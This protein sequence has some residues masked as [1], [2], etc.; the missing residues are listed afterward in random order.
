[1][2][3]TLAARPLGL[4]WSLTLL[5]RLAA[6]WSQPIAPLQ[7][8]FAENQA[9]ADGLR[10]RG[11][12]GFGDD[13]RQVPELAVSFQ[14]FAYE[15]HGAR[16]RTPGVP[17]LLAACDGVGAG[18]RGFQALL[19][20]CDACSAVLLWQLAQRLAGTRAAWLAA[21][22]FA[23]DPLLL[24]MGMRLGREPILGLATLA[25]LRWAVELGD[26]AV[27]STGWR[28]RALQLGVLAGGGALLK[29]SLAPL[30]GVLVAG[31]AWQHR[32][33]LRR[34][35]ALVAVFA[36]ATLA[37]ALPW[38]ARNAAV[39]GHPGLSTMGPV[40]LYLGLLPK[41]RPYA[42]TAAALQLTP[43]ELAA[44][45]EAAIAAAGAV[46]QRWAR[47][48]PLETLAEALRNAGWFWSPVSRYNPP[49]LLVWIA[50]AASAGLIA[51][52]AVGLYQ[53]R[54]DAAVQLIAGLLLAATGLHALAL[55]VP[56]YRAP[57]HAVLWLLAAWAVAA[58]WTRPA[59]PATP[60]A[61]VEPD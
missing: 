37:A 3:S 7:P 2:R 35:A 41:D 52:A 40:A 1:M 44:T 24:S 28:R 4:I 34:A 17:A 16:F 30:I 57:F 27:W 33:D 11:E 21:L 13:W 39:S 14:R 59:A 23:A 6:A 12:F 15:A 55:S 20:L 5:L 19:A 8:D 48:Q 45:P 31:V 47:A 18:A 58:R 38:V 60:P 53:R 10:L 42:A 36:A 46:V 32:A 43:P 51:A 50:A 26:A 9:L 56:R 29:E 49:S 61:A 22:G 54:R 25:A